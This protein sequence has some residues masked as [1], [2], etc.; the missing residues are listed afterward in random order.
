MD[1]NVMGNALNKC[2]LI[3]E[4]YEGVPRSIYDFNILRDLA[5]YDTVFT[6]GQFVGSVKVGSIGYALYARS[7]FRK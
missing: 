4:S 6:K 3:L 5:N 2:G 7:N 1:L